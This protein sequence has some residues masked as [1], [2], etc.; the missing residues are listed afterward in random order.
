MKLINKNLQIKEL[1][2]EW[3]QKRWLLEYKIA[4]KICILT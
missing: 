4:K 3:V 2:K 1:L